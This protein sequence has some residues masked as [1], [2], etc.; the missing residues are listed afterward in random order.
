MYFCNTTDKGGGYFLSPPAQN[1]GTTG[2][3]Y[4][5]QTACDRSG[6]FFRAKLNVVHFGV[7]DDVTGQVKVQMI[8][9]FE[10]LD[11]LGSRAV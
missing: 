2:R 8:D 7:A 1:S 9:D 4:K 5:I 11:L 10:Y 6:F 3:I